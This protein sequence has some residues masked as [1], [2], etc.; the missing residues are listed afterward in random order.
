MWYVLLFSLNKRVS[1][2]GRGLHLVS[3]SEAW[4]GHFA[5][6]S[7]CRV[8]NRF[9]PL[10][11]HCCSVWKQYIFFLATWAHN[12]LQWLCETGNSPVVPVVNPFAIMESTERWPDSILAG[13]RFWSFCTL[14][15]FN[16]D[17][18][19]CKAYCTVWGFFEWPVYQTFQA[20][21]NVH[22]K[23]THGGVRAPRRHVPFLDVVLF[24]VA[25]K[26]LWKVA[27]VELCTKGQWSRAC[28]T[29]KKQRQGRRPLL[30][31]LT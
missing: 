22:G 25:F 5:L 8:K 31:Q 12:L 2:R 14:A 28:W 24:A 29:R 23:F 1:I 20:P 21:E 11:Q 18:R 26:L 7:L 9:L 19:Y 4:F 16:R 10:C 15:I 17:L 6:H 3:P 13:R 27:R 30:L